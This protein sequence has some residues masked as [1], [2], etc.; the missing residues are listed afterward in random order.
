MK[1]YEQS[2]RGSRFVHRVR[3]ARSVCAVDYIVRC[4]NG[5][6]PDS[7]TRQMSDPNTT[8]RDPPDGP[9]R[10]GI[11]FSMTIGS[12]AIGRWLQVV[13]DCVSNCDAMFIITPCILTAPACVGTYHLSFVVVLIVEA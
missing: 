9:V 13:I 4:R 10:R 7:A 11:R 8:G 6:E 2:R 12:I 5:R 3:N 1:P